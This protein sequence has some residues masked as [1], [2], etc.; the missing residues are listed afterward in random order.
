MPEETGGYKRALK[1]VAER[2]QDP[3]AVDDELPEFLVGET[4]QTQ[5][6]NGR[7]KPAPTSLFKWALSAE[8]ERQ[9][10]LVGAGR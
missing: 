10:E 7:P 1:L 4:V 5:G 6:R 3:L 2:L 9:Q 8:Q